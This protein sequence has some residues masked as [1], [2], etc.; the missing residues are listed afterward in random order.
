MQKLVI[1]GAGESG[2]G[3]AILGKKQGYAVFVSDKGSISEKY[4]NVLLHHKIQ[5][6]ENQHTESEILSADLVMKSPGI[7]DKI[8]IVQKLKLKGISIKLE[9]SV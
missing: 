4:K 8:E 1:L 5:F 7:S 3:T 6:E 2:V 9:I